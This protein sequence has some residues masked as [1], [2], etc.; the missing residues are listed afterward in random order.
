MTSRRLPEGFLWGGAT[1]DFQYEGGFN[2]DGRGLISHDY[3]TDGS[4]ENPRHHTM[5]MPD[6]T[7]IRP[8][9]SFFD[10]E[11]VPEE[12]VPVFL[13]DQ[14]YP[15]HQAVDFYHRYE[16]DIKLMAGMGFNV[17]RF[18]ITWTRIFPTGLEEE[19]NEAGLEFYDNVINEMAKYNMEPLITICHD[20]VPMHLALEYD[21]WSSQVTVE[22]Y[23]KLCKVLFERYGDRCK[24]WL[25]FNEINAVKGFGPTGVRIANGKPRYQAAHNMFVASAK[26][27]KMGHE[28]MPGSQFGAMYAMS[29]LYPA[30]CK[31]EDMFQQLQTRR[32]NWYYIDVMGRGYYPSYSQDVW[33]YHGFDSLY[34]TDEDRVIL[35][36]GQLDFI[37]FSYYR[38]NTVQAG[39][40]RFNVGGRLNP[41]LESTPWGW[42][43]DPLGLRYLMNNIYDRIQKPLFIVENG[44]G[45]VDEP[46]ENFFVEDDYRIEYLDDHLTAMS[47]AINIDGVPTIGYTMWA[48]IDL[49]SLSTGE[50]RKRYGF[51][52][53]DMDDKGNGTLNRYPKKSYQWMKKV[54]DTNGANLGQYDYAKSREQYDNYL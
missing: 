16:E 22:A 32:E 19:P 33:R 49:V 24:Y 12:A 2:E 40:K 9:S 42:P 21:G 30:T 5:Q 17:F 53:V 28:M 39:D 27:V 6:G 8:K 46:D 35:K 26:A 25:T 15:S 37:S 47:D 34:I 50:M 18:A 31:P 7:I 45:F 41:H 14:Y 11:D 4:L 54:I 43:V 36:E 1:S 23:L 48:P 44:M 3:E 29:E 38:S 51:V 10:A 13:D 20:E 52:Y